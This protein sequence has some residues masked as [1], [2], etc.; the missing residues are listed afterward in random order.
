MIEAYPDTSC[1]FRIYDFSIE[2]PKILHYLE[3][4]GPLPVSFWLRYEFMQ[5][6]RLRMYLHD[7]GNAR[8]WNRRFGTFVLDKFSADLGQVYTLIPLDLQATIAKA[9]E[10]SARHTR[11]H[12]YRAM[13]I[14]HVATALHLGAK[15]FLSFDKSQR[16]LALAE[17]LELPV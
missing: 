6:V 16:M 7:K 15:A 1:L 12:G 4:N 14:L 9:E 13:D 5:A 17:G 10:L 11:E 8:N 2:T 3:A